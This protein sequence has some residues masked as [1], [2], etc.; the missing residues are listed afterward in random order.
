[1][2]QDGFLENPELYI[3]G[4]AKAAAHYQHS[5]GEQPIQIMQNNMT[6]QQFIGFLRGNVIKYACRMGY[7]DSEVKDAQKAAQYAKWLCYALEGKK[8]NPME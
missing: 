7:K 2:S 5:E 8:I 6:K 3:G 1:M 4:H